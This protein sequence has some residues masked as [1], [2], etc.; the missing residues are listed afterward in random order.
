MGYQ[1]YTYLVYDL[2]TNTALGELPLR[3]ATFNTVL[4]G[5]GT[6][7]GQI[8][9]SDPV[10][11]AMDV[12]AITV[13]GRTALYVD[14]GGVLIWGGIIWQRTY[15]V[16]QN[17]G[18]NFT[19]TITADEFPSYFKQRILASNRTYTNQDQLFIA[20]DLISY[21]QLFSSIGVN[22]P[23]AGTS[24]V[25]LSESY[26]G[27]DYKPFWSMVTEMAS[28]TEG[29]D[30]MIDVGYG[31]G[32]AAAGVPGKNLNLSWPR[33]GTRAPN[34]GLVLELPGYIAQYC[35]PEDATKMANVI[36]DTGPGTGSAML[37][38]FASDPAPL[39]AGYPMLEATY[40]YNDSY[41]T[42][43]LIT[44]R[45]QADLKAYEN[46]V[47]LPVVFIVPGAWPN[48]GDYT[49][50]DDVVISI[51]DLRFPSGM[52]TYM[53]IN[54]IDYTPQDQGRPE[55]IQLTLGAVP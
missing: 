3:Q 35:W 29:F 52:S 32:G 16:G 43:A 33:R 23:T 14:R 47:V 36:Y 19:L 4:N 18:Y 46:G 10:A 26:V 7:N 5:V 45:A 31:I 6:L 50:G 25:L 2:V 48:I 34:N 27:T 38:G 53:R 40:S 55:I 54:R 44:D 1:P 51:T 49:V 9:L 15:S 21:A 37:V 20:S 39:T 41:I 28:G 24:G 30:A 12:P 22:V 13:P 11:Q 42:Q 17:M 8:L